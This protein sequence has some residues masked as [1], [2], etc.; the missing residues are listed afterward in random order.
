MKLN[1][2]LK[3]IQPVEV[4]G[5][6]D[7]EITGVNSDARLVEGGLL[8]MA[9]RGTQTDGPTYITSSLTTSGRAIPC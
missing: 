5:S 9:M 2:L 3:A 4:A 6:T 1:E 7:I 8:F